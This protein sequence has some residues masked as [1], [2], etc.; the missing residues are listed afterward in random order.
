MS[1]VLVARGSGYLG[2][3]VIAALLRDGSPVRAVV[4]SLEGEADVR[5]AVG[6]GGG[7]DSGL[8]VVAAELT[9]DEGRAAAAAAAAGREQVHHTASPMIQAEHPDEVVIPPGR[10]HAQA[11]G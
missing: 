6:R 3:Q 9:A 2:T 10:P 5:A 4:R 1:P 8:E 7:D 11:E